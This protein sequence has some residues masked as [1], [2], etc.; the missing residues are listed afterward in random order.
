LEK[1]PHAAG[2]SCAAL[3]LTDLSAMGE[4][5]IGGLLFVPRLLQQIG[6]LRS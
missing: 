5:G 3:G 1:A 6:H 2:R 4:L